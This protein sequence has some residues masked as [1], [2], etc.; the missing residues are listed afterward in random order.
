MQYRVDADGIEEIASQIRIKHNEILSTI[1][2]LR[3]LNSSLDSFW[4]GKSQKQFEASFGN[5]LV[6]LDQFSEKLE[7]VNQYLVT[8]VAA[9]RLLED[10]ATGKAG[11]IS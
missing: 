1:T 8:F 10:D 11:I 7:S 6:Q 5:W 3:S 9:R 4:D 2:A